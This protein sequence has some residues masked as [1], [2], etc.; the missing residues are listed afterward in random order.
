MKDIKYKD[1]IVMN[2]NLANRVTYSQYYFIYDWKSGPLSGFPFGS[3]R[4]LMLFIFKFYY[5]IKLI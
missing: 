4:P 5:Y 2:T 1:N 3:F